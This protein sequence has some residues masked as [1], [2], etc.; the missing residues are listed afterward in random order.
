MADRAPADPVRFKEA[1]DWFRS[2]LPVTQ[3]E[4]DGM[5]LEARRQAFT[6][7]GVQQLDAVST[8]MDL[9]QESIDKGLPIDDFRAKVKA[10]LGDN[11]GSSGANLKTAYINAHQTAYNTGRWHQMQATKAVL[12]F[13]RFDAILDG[14]ETEICHECAG[15]ILP[16]DH[17]WWQTHFCPLHHRCR[18][19]VR[20]LTERM[21]KRHGGV[22]DE[23][24]RPN[25][26]GDWGLDP[27]IRDNWEPDL[28]KYEAHIAREYA[29]KQ[30]SM[31]AANDNGDPLPRPK[32][33]K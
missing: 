33:K 30:K 26:T 12:P 19:T 16:A 31:K 13:W 29:K 18:S 28:N 2:K 11:F 1:S 32:R 27:S 5:R 15:T 6:L 4:W 24:P 21:A 9:L 3:E 25:I 17:P 14:R 7:A 23:P 20:A 8:L 22:T 10:K